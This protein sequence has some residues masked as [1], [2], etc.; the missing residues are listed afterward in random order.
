MKCLLICLVLTMSVSGG[1]HKDI[2]ELT[3]E[4]WTQTLL[5]FVE[6]A[7]TVK[8]LLINLVQGECTTG[9]CVRFSKEY[10]QLAK[11]V[12]NQN[13]VAHVD[14]RGEDVVCRNVPKPKI[15]NSCSTI[16]MT[17]DAVY[18]YD[19][20]QTKEALLDWLSA[21]KFKDSEVLEEGMQ[22]YAE[23]ATGMRMPV[24]ARLRK[25]FHETM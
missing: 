24:E 15:R 18:G 2:F 8:P 19:G 13:R 10:H 16:Y 4:N 1:L 25:W 17:K 21:D 12:K 20:N 5:E 22:Q 11:I 9:A 23:R 6:K 7:D 3:N 14:C